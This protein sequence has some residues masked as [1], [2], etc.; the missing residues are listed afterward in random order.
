MAADDDRVRAELVRDGSLF[1]G[2]HPQMAAVH[3]RHAEALAAIVAEHGWP[4]RSLVGEEAAEAAW[5]L[6]QHA[7][8]SPDLQRRCMG[9]LR[10][11]AD[12]GDIPLS[13]PALLEDRIA[14]CERRPQRYGTQF[15]WDAARV[16][17][18]WPI[19]DPATVEQR[20]TQVG[21]SPLAEAVRR[22]REQAALEGEVPPANYERRQR[23]I[24]EWACR[25]GW[26]GATSERG[27][28]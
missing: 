3:A 5:R 26:L 6:L 18:P 23:E 10:A 15:D 13:Y 21:L 8:G 4:G 1:Q 7:I 2:Y 24:R 17:S 9:P 20:R 16:M 11:A 14:F 25:T 27:D 28:A 22:A 19:L 12:R